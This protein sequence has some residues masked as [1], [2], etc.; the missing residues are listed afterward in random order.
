MCACAC[1]GTRG[2]GNMHRSAM[3]SFVFVA[4]GAVACSGEVDRGE[5]GIA[6]VSQPLTWIERQKFAPSDL[7]P[8]VADFPISLS[9]KTALVGVVEDDDEVPIPDRGAAFVFQRSGTTWT[10]QQ[11]LVVSDGAD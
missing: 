10:E 5:T 8:D 7:P 4:T 9:G 2:A 6:Q 11:E 3:L 1:R